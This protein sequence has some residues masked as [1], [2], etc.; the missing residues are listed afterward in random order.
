MADLTEQVFV[1]LTD[2]VQMS[3]AAEQTNSSMYWWDSSD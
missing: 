2:L 1:L 3:S